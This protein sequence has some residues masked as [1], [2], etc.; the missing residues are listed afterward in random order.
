MMMS[1]MIA[2]GFLIV[3]LTIVITYLIFGLGDGDDF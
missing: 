1:L 2:I 3:F